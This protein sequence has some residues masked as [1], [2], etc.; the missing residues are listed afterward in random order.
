MDGFFIAETKIEIVAPI[1][2]IRLPCNAVQ[3][4]ANLAYLAR[5]P[6]ITL[7]KMNPAPKLITAINA[8]AS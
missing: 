3:I 5:L 4:P 8:A 7:E 1:I 6:A 2:S